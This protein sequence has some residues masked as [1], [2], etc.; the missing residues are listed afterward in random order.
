[1]IWAFI[2]TGIHGEPGVKRVK[3]LY[4]QSIFI[5]NDRHRI[6]QYTVYNVNKVRKR[7]A[8]RIKRI[9]DYVT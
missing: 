9:I 3:V 6:S 8:I 2:S 5:T 7:Q 4:K 1:M